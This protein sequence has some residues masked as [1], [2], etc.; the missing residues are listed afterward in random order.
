MPCRSGPKTQEVRTVSCAVAQ[1]LGQRELGVA[2]GPAVDRQ[3]M[4]RGVLGVRAVPAV[5]DVVRGEVDEPGPD[6]GRGA[7]QVQGLLELAA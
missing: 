3:R 4:G 6:L 5:E 1:R 2:L 7:G